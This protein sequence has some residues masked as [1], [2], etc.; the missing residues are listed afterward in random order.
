[1]DSS[2]FG[3]RFSHIG[4]YV[5]DIDALSRFYKDM[6]GYTETDRG[7]LEGPE[8]KFGLVFLS[9]D[10]D[11]HHQIVMVAGRPTGLTFNTINQ[12][13]MKA[14]SVETLQKYYRILQQSPAT[15]IT[16]ITHGNAISVYFCDPERNRVELYVDTPWYVSQPCRVE[17][18]IESSPAELM[19]WAEC[20]ARSLP[21]F[22]PRSEWRREM[23]RRMQ[24]D[25][26]RTGT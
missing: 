14:D 3:L 10:P 6:L 25:R 7:E 18:P 2:Q 5:T 23:E 8:G 17:A 13:S 21:G 1:M 15:E 19:A 11:E 24:A 26:Q 4:I 16:A 12:I 20:H 22:R 9:R